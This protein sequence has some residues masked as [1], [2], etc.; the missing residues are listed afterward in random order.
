MLQ[1]VPGSAVNERG[2]LPFAQEVELAVP[3]V[4]ELLLLQ[5][6]RVLESALGWS[7]A[8]VTAGSID[9]TC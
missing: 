6:A 7:E 1:S 8:T 5:P 2:C 4:S 9:A 3:G